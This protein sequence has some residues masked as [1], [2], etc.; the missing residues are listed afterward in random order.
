LSPC[1]SVLLPEELLGRGW[2]AFAGAIPAGPISN[3]GY[4]AV[5]SLRRRWSSNPDV[6]V[7]ENRI[8][9]DDN[10]AT[11]VAAVRK[12]RGVYANIVSFTRFQI[13]TALGFVAPS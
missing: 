11:I 1:R 5:P 10:F 13:S 3:S 4:A 8:L 7:G 9:T 12:G 2:R 6:P